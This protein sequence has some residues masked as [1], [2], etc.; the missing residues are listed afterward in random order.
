M[1]IL[2][3]KFEKF[4][5]RWNKNLIR[6]CSLRIISGGKERDA[7]G[8]K[9][10]KKGKREAG[11]REAER[12]RGRERDYE[13]VAVYEMPHNIYALRSHVVTVAGLA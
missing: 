11:Q 1:A 2:S 4:Y 7:S 12:N 3:I 13:T 6:S 9:R 10:K 8:E 5:F